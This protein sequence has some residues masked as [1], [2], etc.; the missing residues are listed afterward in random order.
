MHIKKAPPQSMVLAHYYFMVGF[1]AQL[2]CH[3]N[4]A[5]AGRR[6]D[7]INRSV[8]RSAHGAV[9]RHAIGVLRV[10]SYRSACDSLNTRRRPLAACHG[11]C[12]C[13]GFTHP[14]VDVEQTSTAVGGRARLER[15][16][17]RFLS[18][19]TRSDRV[20]KPWGNGI[21]HLIFPCN[22][23]KEAGVSTLSRRIHVRLER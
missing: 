7:D 12:D 11:S 5:V 18:F 9:H 4:W 16:P 17:Q 10:D 19:H 14:A 20:L 8:I 3:N 21:S 1:V 2:R 6:C 15:R 22:S 13:R 23:M